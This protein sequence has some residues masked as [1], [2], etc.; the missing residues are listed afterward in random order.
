MA[1][2]PGLTTLSASV[3]CT[4]S[5]WIIA[6]NA[7]SVVES[8]VQERIKNEVQQ[9]WRSLVRRFRRKGL[10]TRVLSHS[11]DGV[12]NVVDAKVAAERSSSKKSASCDTSCVIL[13]GWRRELPDFAC[14]VAQRSYPVRSAC[15]RWRGRWVR[16]RRRGFLR[17]PTETG[18]LR[19]RRLA[20]LE[21]SGSGNPK[22]FGRDA[23]SPAHHWLL[24]LRLERRSLTQRH[25]RHHQLVRKV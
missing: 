24:R 17:S 22:W 15:P 3:T 13:G 25:Q 9:C 16:G 23:G 18:S 10:I 14:V 19:F 2:I 21:D 8:E 20:H 11:G 5:G 4:V 6:A 12:G 7:N 1:S